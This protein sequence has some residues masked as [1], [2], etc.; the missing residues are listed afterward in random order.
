MY[1]NRALLTDTTR[2]NPKDL[3][4]RALLM[5]TTRDKTDGFVQ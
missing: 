2:E 4:D 3:S 1:Q 5:D